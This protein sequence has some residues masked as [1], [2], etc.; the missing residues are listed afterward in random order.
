MLYAAAVVNGE[1]SRYWNKLSEYLRLLPMATD[2]DLEAK[3]R[4]FWLKTARERAN[5]SQEAVAKELG[6]SGRSKSTMSAWENGTREPKLSYL[7]AMSRLYQVPVSIFVDPDKMASE[8]LEER[9][10]LL[11]RAAIRLARH[12][13][14]PEEGDVPQP[15]EERAERHGKQRA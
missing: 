6:L 13:L 9:L 7:N 15:G 10:S 4:G 14:G 1:T 8:L 12:D 2:P 11:A 5:L 3:R